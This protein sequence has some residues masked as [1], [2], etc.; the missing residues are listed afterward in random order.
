MEIK[1]KRSRLKELEG[2]EFKMQCMEAG[3][4]DNWEWYDES[5][6]EYQ[7]VKDRE[8]AI[9]AIFEELLEVLSSTAY[10]P[11]ESGAGIAFRDSE[12]EDAIKILTDG[13]NKIIKDEKEVDDEV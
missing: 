3:G 7:K 8:E 10:E 13:L 11:S 6:K 1:I 2:I 5:L 4:V 12:Q 9:E